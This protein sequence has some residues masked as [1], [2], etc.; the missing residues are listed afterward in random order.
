M[1]VRREVDDIIGEG[2][3]EASPEVSETANEALLSATQ[4]VSKLLAMT[5][6]SL[7][8]ICGYIEGATSREACR[9]GFRR[10]NEVIRMFLVSAP[11]PEGND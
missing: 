9:D 10:F 1:S 7:E 5:N 4:E 2:G 8:E 6:D 3:S 11:D